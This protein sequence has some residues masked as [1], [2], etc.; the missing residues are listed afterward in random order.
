MPD[1]SGGEE[2]MVVDVQAQGR[3]WGGPAPTNIVVAPKDEVKTFSL[4]SFIEI[5]HAEGESKKT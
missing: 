5:Y 4:N 2:M 1:V 3:G